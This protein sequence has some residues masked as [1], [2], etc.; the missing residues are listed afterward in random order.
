LKSQKLLF[1]GGDGSYCGFDLKLVRP[2][3]R[4]DEQ[5]SSLVEYEGLENTDK[6]GRGTKG[7]GGK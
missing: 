3:A 1:A 6:G 7:K 5:T 4:Y 2:Q